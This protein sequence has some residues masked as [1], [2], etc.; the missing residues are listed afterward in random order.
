MTIL[1]GL[2]CFAAGLIVGWNFLPQPEF[3]K[4]WIAQLRA[5]L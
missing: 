2:I 1:F 4:N 3:V 5:K